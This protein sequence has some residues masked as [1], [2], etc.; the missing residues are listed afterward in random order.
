MEQNKVKEMLETIGEE[1]KSFNLIVTAN[2]YILVLAKA[3]HPIN[4]VVKGVREIGGTEASWLD[5]QKLYKLA[6]NNKIKDAAEFEIVEKRSGNPVYS[7]LVMT[8]TTQDLQTEFK[9]ILVSKQL[10]KFGK[11]IVT[12]IYQNGKTTFTRP[13]TNEDENE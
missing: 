6:Y 4:P 2:G 11:L 13:K 10:T 5:L 3:G 8:P 9:K 7:I 1:S 12:A